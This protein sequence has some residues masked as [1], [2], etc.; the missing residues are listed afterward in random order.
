MPT[1]NRELPS[2]ADRFPTFRIWGQRAWLIPLLLA[3]LAG[4]WWYGLHAD[5]HR[6]TILVQG[7][8]REYLW[9]APPATDGELRPL[10]LALHGFSGTAAGMAESSKLHEL[11]NEQNFYLAYLEGDPTWQFF[12]RED[13][14]VSL[15]VA[16]FDRL[17]EELLARYPIDPDRIYVAGMSRG[18][19]FAVYLAERRSTR[20]AAV[21]SQGACVAEPEDTERLFPLMIIVGT[22]DERVPADRFPGVPQAFRDR[23]HLVEVLRPENVGH[24]WHVPLNGQVWEFLSAQRLS[25]EAEQESMP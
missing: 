17:C 16:F 12:V 19:D 14:D 1:E 7:H 25:N 24:R 13:A 8:E 4:M 18:G 22:R 20:I 15:D 5:P 21:V 23:G 2:R 3:L 9:Y 11:A 10:V 6:R